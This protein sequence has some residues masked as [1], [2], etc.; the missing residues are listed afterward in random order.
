M[1]STGRAD[2]LLYTYYYY[3]DVIGSGMVP[4]IVPYLVYLS[5]CGGQ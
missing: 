3:E 5:E 1:L 4:Y 2:I